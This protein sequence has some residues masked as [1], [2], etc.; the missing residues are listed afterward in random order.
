MKLSSILLHSTLVLFVSIGVGAPAM[1]QEVEPKSQ[2]QISQEKSTGTFLGSRISNILFS[3]SDRLTRPEDFGDDIQTTQGAGVAD[4][5]GYSGPIWVSL[6]ARRSTLRGDDMDLDI[7]TVGGDVISAPD[8]IFGVMFQ[9]DVSTQDATDGGSFDATGYMAGFYGISQLG[10]VT[11][12]LRL[13]AGETSNDISNFG[14]Q[15]DDVK[16]ERWLAAFQVLST[17]ELPNGVLLVPNGGFSWFEDR[18][19]AYTIGATPVEEETIRYGQANFGSRAFIPISLGATQGD[20]VLAA[21]TIYGFG[22]SAGEEVPEGV[23]AR[24][25]L[26]VEFYNAD[27]WQASAGVFFDGVG[28]EEYEAT[29]LDLGVTLWF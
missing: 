1:A 27:V 13:S 16:S 25:D 14:A 4:L 21:S 17:E 2:Q 11:F 7:V 19:E 23:R 12:D 6:S 3:Q 20:V 22:P 29:G 18:M 8:G 28:L 15:V 9:G 5:E 26:G 10:S 24:L